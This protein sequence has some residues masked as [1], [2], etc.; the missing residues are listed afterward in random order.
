MDYL[1]VNVLNQLDIY[2]LILVRLTALFMLIPFFAQ[3]NIS[4]YI[5]IGL[6]AFIAGILIVSLPPMDIQY[7]NNL[8]GYISIVMKEF[9]VGLIIGFTGYLAFS[10]FYL[11]GQMTDFQIGFSMV[12]VF[13]PISQIQVPIT[14]NIYYLLATVI[15]LSINGHHSIIRSLYESFILIPIG[16]ANFSQEVIRIIVQNVANAFYTGIKISIPIVVS[17]FILDVSLGFLTRVA[18]QLNVFA[19]GFILKITLGLLAIIIFIPAFSTIADIVIN[20][21]FRDILQLIKAMGTS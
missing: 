18:P 1:L 8:L 13:D 4:S 9:V 20:G 14:G 6:S 15:L 3:Q 21:M 19:V 2:I 7:D 5:K 17:L 16:Q 10:V 11:A 12:N